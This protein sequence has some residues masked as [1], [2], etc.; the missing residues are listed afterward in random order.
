[1]DVVGRPSSLMEVRGV[2]EV[3]GVMEWGSHCPT[4]S[5]HHSITP[6]PHSIIPP[7]PLHH[8]FPKNALCF[9]SKLQSLPKNPAASIAFVPFVST[10]VEKTV[11]S[12]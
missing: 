5:L 1:M 6:P 9:A 4:P 7:S 8:S 2:M 3:T 12:G 10:S 11:Q